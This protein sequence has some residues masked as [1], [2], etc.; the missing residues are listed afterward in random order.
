MKEIMKSF[1]LFAAIFLGVTN[2]RA[3]VGVE[4]GCYVKAPEVAGKSSPFFL[5]KSYI[6]YDLQERVGALLEYNLSL[7]H[8]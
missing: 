7:I 5:F 4:S 6:D 2:A 1:I 3:G 8:I